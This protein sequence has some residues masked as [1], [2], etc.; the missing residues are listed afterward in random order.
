[1]SYPGMMWQQLLNIFSSF[2]I[3]SQDGLLKQF[4]DDLHSGK[5]HRE[6]HYGPDPVTQ[7]HGQIQGGGNAPSAA[8]AQKRNTSPPES[9]FKQLKPSHNRY[10]VL[11]D[12]L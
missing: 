5:L 12:E 10:T 2:F 8:P 3:Y 11:K 6:F 7:P 9:V 4:V 1:M